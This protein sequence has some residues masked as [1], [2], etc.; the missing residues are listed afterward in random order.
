MRKEKSLHI[1]KILNILGFFFQIFDCTIF[2]QNNCTLGKPSRNFFLLMMPQ[3]SQNPV[4]KEDKP[5]NALAAA[6]EAKKAAETIKNRQ[7][8]LLFKHS[9]HVEASIYTSAQLPPP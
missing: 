2:A 7:T 1:T 9:H 3:L 5:Q 8:S 6:R 4:R